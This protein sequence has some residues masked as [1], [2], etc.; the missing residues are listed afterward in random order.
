MKGFDPHYQDFP[1]YILK[2]TKEILES[3][4]LEEGANSK[5]ASF[6]IE[7]AFVG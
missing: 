1:D 6:V 4:G 5:P 2:I 7:R 3:F